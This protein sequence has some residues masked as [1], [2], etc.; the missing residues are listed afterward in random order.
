MY[1]LYVR[2]H[3]DCGDIIYHKVDPELSPDFTKKPESTQYS[4]ALAVNGAWRGTSK[5]KL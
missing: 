4:A 1:K 5:C 2:S 3:L